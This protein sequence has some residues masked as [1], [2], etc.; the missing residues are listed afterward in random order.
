MR[1][2][3]GERLLQLRISSGASQRQ[4]AAELGMSQQRYQYYEANKREPDIETLI[5]FADYYKVPVDFLI[6]RTDSRQNQ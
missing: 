4:L 1:C 2:T 3:V 5:M 6:G